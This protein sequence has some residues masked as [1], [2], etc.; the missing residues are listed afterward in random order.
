MRQL[1]KNRH[2]KRCAKLTGL[3]LNSMRLNFDTRFHKFF[4]QVYLVIGQEK[5]NQIFNL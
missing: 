5:T 3:I 1:E 4:Y 2:S